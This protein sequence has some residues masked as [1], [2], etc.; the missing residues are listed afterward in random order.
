ML[1]MPASLAITGA[2]MRSG[3]PM[4]CTYNAYGSVIEAANEIEIRDGPT[5]RRWSLRYHLHYTIVCLSDCTD[6]HGTDSKDQVDVIAITSAH[7]TTLMFFTTPLSTTASRRF[8]TT[9][10]VMLTSRPPHVFNVTVL[11]CHER[12]VAW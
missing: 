1:S 2:E 12:V 7:C 5:H 8:L 10:V 3:V 4:S 6:N 9:L 11:I